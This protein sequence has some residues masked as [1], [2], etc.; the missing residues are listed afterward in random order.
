M[1]FVIPTLIETH[2][3]PTW[4]LYSGTNK[5]EI[6][7][8]LRWMAQLSFRYEGGSGVD[9]VQ[10]WQTLHPWPEITTSLKYVHSCHG[11]ILQ[12]RSNS[13]WNISNLHSVV[14]S[15]CEL[16]TSKWRRVALGYLLHSSF[17]LVIGNYLNLS[18]WEKCTMENWMS[19]GNRVAVLAKPRLQWQRNQWKCDIRK[20]EGVY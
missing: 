3:N 9:W 15:L 11:P 2:V 20:I 6:E 7:R 4:K 18:Q 14:C 8:L 5:D 10:R 17:Y 16:G 19:F 13:F 1:L 12:Y